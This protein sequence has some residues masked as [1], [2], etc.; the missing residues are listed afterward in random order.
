ML[1]VTGNDPPK[2]DITSANCSTVQNPS[3]DPFF[4]DTNKYGLVIHVP[5]FLEVVTSVARLLQGVEVL[6]VLEAGV[7]LG[8]KL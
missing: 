8:R 4:Q 6:R 3:F 2:E 5:E 7:D 1:R